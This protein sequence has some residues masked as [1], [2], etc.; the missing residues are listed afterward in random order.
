MPALTVAQGV[1]LTAG[2]VLT[3][4][5][6]VHQRAKR[7]RE[8][9]RTCFQDLYVATPEA[10]REDIVSQLNPAGQQA[11][12]GNFHI[13][14]WGQAQI[15]NSLAKVYTDEWWPRSWA[16]RKVLTGV[17]PDCDWYADQDEMP[18]E[19]KLVWHAAWRIADAVEKDME[20]NKLILPDLTTNGGR[21]I[22]K[23]ALGLG[24]GPNGELPAERYV[25]FVASDAEG[26]YTEPLVAISRPEWTMQTG[27]VIQDFQ[28]M[29]VPAGKTFTRP[30]YY[31][32]HGFN[33]GDPFKMA[34]AA[35]LDTGA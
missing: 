18:N 26:L 20:L 27:Y 24:L 6:V 4:V 25:V 13:N 14:P 28:V 35:L 22:S 5:A 10:L 23:E 31:N 17:A 2:A 3:G 30:R 33:T 8:A 32:R 29:G 34:N 11:A 1:L 7:R 15:F 16:L 21:V 19:Q 9:A 12:A